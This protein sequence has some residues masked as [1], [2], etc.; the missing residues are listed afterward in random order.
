[1]TFKIFLVTF[2]IF[3][4]F[5]LSEAQ[6]VPAMFVF[7]DSLVDVGN[8][9]HLHLSLAKADIPHYGLDFPTNKPNGRFTNGMNAADFL[10]CD[11]RLEGDPTP[12][13]REPPQPEPVACR[14]HSHGLEVTHG[15][16]AGLEVTHG[17][18]SVLGLP[19][20]IP[21]GL[22]V[23]HGLGLPPGVA[24][25]VNG[26]GLNVVTHGLE[27]THG[28]AAGLE[29]T[30]GQGSVLGLPC[31][32]PAGLEVTHGLGLPPGVAVPTGMSFAN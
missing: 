14:A 1:M 7:G 19:C 24:G 30:H 21:A 26:V 18:G 12:R 3:I 11:P 5:N 31:L 16:A 6:K 10:G 27:V 23:T 2:F 25:V 8:N 28:L 32:I 20:L 22:E 4:A 9:N 17:Q 15:L 13:R 29:V